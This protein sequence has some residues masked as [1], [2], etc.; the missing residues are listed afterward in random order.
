L[1]LRASGV[2]AHEHVLLRHAAQHGRRAAVVTGRRAQLL[3]KKI[4]RRE[5]P[6]RGGEPRLTQ[7]GVAPFGDAEVFQAPSRARRRFG[8]GTKRE[9]SGLAPEEVFGA[10]HYGQA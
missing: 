2:D 9:V 1:E 10:V 6:V 5:R 8:Y 4:P 7:R 3:S